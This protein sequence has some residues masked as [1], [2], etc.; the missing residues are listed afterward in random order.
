MSNRQ[1]KM[2]KLKLRV[3][4]DFRYATK[5]SETS[6]TGLASSIVSVVASPG[7]ETATTIGGKQMI[8]PLEQCSGVKNEGAPQGSPPPPRKGMGLTGSQR[9]VAIICVLQ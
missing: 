2:T 9:Y 1:F 8:D 6:L 3:E 5:C 4:T 7:R